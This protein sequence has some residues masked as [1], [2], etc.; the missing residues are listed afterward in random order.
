MCGR[1][2][3]EFPKQVAGIGHLAIQKKGGKDESCYE[4]DGSHCVN[5]RVSGNVGD[6]PFRPVLRLCLWQGQ[7]YRIK[8]ISVRGHVDAGAVADRKPKL[9]VWNRPGHGHGRDATGSGFGCLPGRVFPAESQ[10]RP[11]ENVRVGTEL[12]GGG[13][14]QRGDARQCGG[15][16]AAVLGFHVELIRASQARCG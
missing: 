6:Q 2:R 8:F 7:R 4:A 12:R 9:P 5:V 10:Q 11:E 15:T 3:P 1:V 14:N 16:V 13:N